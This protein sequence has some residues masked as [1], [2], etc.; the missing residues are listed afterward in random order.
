MLSN[1]SHSGCHTLDDCG[2]CLPPGSSCSP[3]KA[4]H[5]SS[6]HHHG[7]F[8]EEWSAYATQTFCK[9]GT[10]KRVPWED[11][12]WRPIIHSEWSRIG[13]ST[14]DET[15]LNS[16]LYPQGQGCREWGFPVKSSSSGPGFSSQL[17]DI[18]HGNHLGHPLS[19]LLACTHTDVL[20][21][22][23]TLW[24]GNGIVWEQKPYT[25]GT[26]PQAKV[27]LFSGLGPALH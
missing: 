15:V 6:V 25:A 12:N 13:K 7:V 21:H 1:L 17:L 2:W 22:S 9:T 24:Q 8:L 3:S 23:R 14:C 20:V 5:S 10:L 26:D 16:P 4:Q 11:R 19:F 27:M 18:T